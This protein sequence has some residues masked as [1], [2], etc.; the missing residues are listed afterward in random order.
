MIED[1]EKNSL[2]HYNTPG[3]RFMVS[4]CAML[5]FLVAFSLTAYYTW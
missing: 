4:L 2:R 1:R 5:Y 3:L